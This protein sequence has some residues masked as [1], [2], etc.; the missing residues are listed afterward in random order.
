MSTTL[1]EKLKNIPK[2]PGVYRY[3]D[4]Q[5]TLLYIGKAKNLKNRVSSYFVKTLESAKTRQLVSKIADIK[6]IVTDSE[7]DALLLENTLVKEYQP[8]YNI[9]LRDDKTYPWIVIKKEPFPRV[10]PTRNLIKDGSEYFGPYASVKTMYAL[11]DFLRKMH[12]LRTCNLNLTDDNIKSGKFKTCLEFQI[13]NCMAPCVGKQT[14]EDYDRHIR[15][16]R[17]ILK[18]NIAEV[19]KENKEQMQ[20]HADRMEFEAAQEIKERVALLEH[21]QA[22]STVVQPYI[23]NVDVF[24][25]ICDDKFGYVNYMKIMSG[26]VIQSHTIEL[27]KKLDEAEEELLLTAIIELRH[28]FN[29]DSEEIFVNITVDADWPG[30][31]FHIPQRGDKKLLTDMSLRNAKYFMRDRHLQQEKTDPDRHKNRV[32]GKLQSDL[33]MQVLPEH[34]ECFDNSNIQG[35]FPVAACVVFK[36]AKPSKKDYRHFNIK[37][38]EGPDDF[39]SMRE[40]IYRRYSRMLEENIPLPQ[41]V[42]ID[43]GKGQLSSAVESLKKLAIYGQ[44][45]VVGIAKKLEEIYFPG[46]SFPIYIDKRSESLKLIQQLRN[47]AHRFGIT[48]HRNRRSK[49]TIKTGLEEIPGIGPK[50]AEKLL[51]H[52]N[53]VKRIKMAETEA[54]AEVV[55]HKT[56]LKIKKELKE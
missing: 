56:A 53:S 34:I 43:G 7:Y 13:G 41:L 30:I 31:K 35:A 40:V 8:R 9:Q 4:A 6:Y 11:L 5:G 54:L 14:H 38:V 50:T 15:H 45:T 33:R 55:G 22:R 29:S 24:S 26:C 27:K 32:L 28:R 51:R 47:E 49:G 23:H 10:F 21:Y 42:I 46:D 18:G 36:D 44:V 17:K 2:K 3:F 20:Q 37:T 39:A 48:H 16:I 1:A 25:I 12:P 19:I 52:F